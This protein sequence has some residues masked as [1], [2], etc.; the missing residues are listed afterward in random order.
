VIVATPRAAVNT[1]RVV[2]AVRRRLLSL[3]QPSVPLRRPS[4]DELAAPDHP[5]PAFVRA[6]PVA[7]HYLALLGGLPWSQFPERAMDRPW[8]G[9]QPAPRAPLAA[10]FLVKIDRG[11]R[12]MSDLREYLVEHPALVWVLGFELVADAASPHGFD[13]AAS[14]PTRRQLGRVLREMDTAQLGWLLDGVVAALAAVVPD[15][16]VGDT[17]SLDTKHILA[18]VRENNPKA[19]VSERFNPE[20]QPAGDP[21]CRLGCKKRHNTPPTEGQPASTATRGEFYWGYASG[22]VATH[23]ADGTEVVLAELTQTFDRADITYFQP[24][25]AQVEERLGRRPRFGALDAAFDAFYVYDYFDQA[26]GFAAVPLVAKGGVSVRTFDPSGNPICEAGLAMRL[27]RTFMNR[28]SYVE[29]ERGVWTCPLVGQAETC[30]VNHA[31]WP[32]GGCQTTMATAPGA[33]LR[34]QLDRHGEDYKLVYNQR[35]AVERINSQATAL[36]IER[37]RLRNRAAIANHNTLTYVLIDLRALGRLRSRRQELL[38][39]A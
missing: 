25:M 19:F 6:C 37:P 3:V 9:P 22:V 4:L 27:G 23:L 8:P 14:L 1:G 15:Q 35:T 17:I 30:P 29:H 5:L 36:G 38:R 24:L 34:Y 11:L 20:R 28:T 33:H 12:Y 7:Q 18:W 26:G 2:G 10:A 32:K 16:L 31:K 13:A 21:D 39:A